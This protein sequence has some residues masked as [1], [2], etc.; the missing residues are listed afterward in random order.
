MEVSSRLVYIYWSTMINVYPT[1]NVLV[2]TNL[3]KPILPVTICSLLQV[4]AD[5]SCI[6]GCFCPTGMLEYNDQCVSRS[7]H[8][9]VYTHLYKPVLPVFTSSHLFF[10][11]G[12][13]RYQLY[14]RM[15]LSTWNI[16]IGI[17]CVSYS[18]RPCVYTHL[19]KPLSPV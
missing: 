5:T 17:Q 4:Y 12:V 9:C 8:P 13:H 18:Q 19:Y 2:Y 10:I 3:Y 14:R 15:F 1:V 16:S 6:D 7:Q 11:I